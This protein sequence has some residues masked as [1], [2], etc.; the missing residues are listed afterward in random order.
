LLKTQLSAGNV[1]VTAY[2][3]RTANSGLNL[4]LVN[5]DAVQNLTLTIETNQRI[6][7]ATAQ[8]MTGPSLSATSGVTIQDATV[9]K[10]GSFTPAS[11]VTLTASAS[12]TTCYI[13]AL[14]ATLI[15]IT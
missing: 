14:S 12:Q 5:K 9:S 2:A 6:E 15:C 3:L 8:T 1:D 4:M 10:D 11:P 13:P 7:T